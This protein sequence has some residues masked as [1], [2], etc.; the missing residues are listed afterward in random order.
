[1]ESEGA[2]GGSGGHE[3]ACDGVQHLRAFLQSEMRTLTPQAFNE[4]VQK[5]LGALKEG[6]RSLK[7]MQLAR[8]E[9][10]VLGTLDALDQLLS[11]KVRRPLP[12]TAPQSLLFGR[13]ATLHS[14]SKWSTAGLSLFAR[15]VLR[16][17]VEI[18]AQVFRRGRLA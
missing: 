3:K 12:C 13:T 14:V 7:G 6:M 9:E 4:L 5:V 15:L 17:E 8:Q 18:T 2:A 11:V 10:V 1:M 16:A